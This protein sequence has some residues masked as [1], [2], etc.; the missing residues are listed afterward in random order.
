MRCDVKHLVYQ[1]R[2]DYD[3]F[4]DKQHHTISEYFKDFNG[5]IEFMKKIELENQMLDNQ[6][7]AC[8]SNPKIVIKMG[9]ITH[10]QYV[11]LK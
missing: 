8:R 6:F 7:Y 1:V 2:Y 5:V 3:D 10:K 9:Y 11:S 4:E